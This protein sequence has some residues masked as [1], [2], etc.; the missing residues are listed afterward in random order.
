MVCVC[1]RESSDSLEQLK[2]LLRVME[3]SVQGDEKK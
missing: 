3:D 1:V 2:K